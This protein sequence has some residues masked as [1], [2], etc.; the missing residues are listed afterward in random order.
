M[1]IS[2][3]FFP[4]T[5]TTLNILSGFMAIVFTSQQQFRYAAIFILLAAIFDATDGI[6]ARLFKTSSQFGVELDSL[7]DVVSF[8]A[9]PAFLIYMSDLIKYD[10]WGALISSLLLIF[11]ALRLARFN[12]QIED[13]DKK[14]DFTGLPIPLSAVTIAT[15]ILTA[16]SPD[17]NSLPE[18]YSYY[19]IP[20]I[21]LLSF[22][23]VSKVR[24]NTL[25]KLKDRRL[26]EKI[27]LLI[28]LVIAF[29]FVF[30]T[31]GSGL[32]YIFISIVLFGIFRQLIMMIVK[33]N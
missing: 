15:Y 22:L 12:S 21:I 20:L 14:E 19:A 24:Y 3:S 1:K 2:K 26:I 4:N 7:S 30:I 33:T 17:T 11:G 16:I 9:A 28:I 8:G 10:I 18:P 13:L 29:I 32:F 6:I 27:V 25:P 31:N 23:M 5:V